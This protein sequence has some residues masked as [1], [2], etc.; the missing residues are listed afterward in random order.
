[1][2]IFLLYTELYAGTAKK[3]SINDADRILI[4]ASD[5]N[6]DLLVRRRQ[7]LVDG[8][9]K[10]SP[11][12]FNQLFT[13]HVYMAGSVVQVVYAL[14][15]NYKTQTTYQRMLT[16]FCKLRLFD[17]ETIMTDFEQAIMSAFRCLFPSVSQSG[18]FYHF[19]QC[20]Y[21]QVQQHG[22]QKL[23]YYVAE[24]FPLFIRMLAAIA[25]VP[26]TDAVD[27]FDTVVDA[28][29]PDRVEPVVNYFED[30]FIGWPDRRGNHRN[31]V[32]PLTLW[33][34][35]RR[36]VESLPRTNNSVEGW[37][38]GFQSS[39]QCSRPTLW[40]L[41]DQ[42]IWENELHRLTVAQLLAANTHSETC[43]PHYK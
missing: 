38:G 39:L 17:P 6:L 30:N 34:V 37:H 32:F 12:V 18:C 16:E 42:L 15:P 3:F 41:L 9:F 22:L 1:M 29:Y 2:F 7:W 5:E 13:L 8:T 36:V 35:N 25:F 33:N 23:S 43:L 14:L 24:D 31:T 26:V 19:S 21:R 11:S 10:C 4:F 40:K 27:S 28:G 20:M